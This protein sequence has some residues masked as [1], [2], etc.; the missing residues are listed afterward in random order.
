L[1]LDG[2]LGSHFETARANPGTDRDDQILWFAAELLT[3]GVDRF[4]RD[5]GNYAAPS[6]VN[7]S[8][9]PILWIGNQYRK[10]IGGPDGEPDTGPV[11]DQRVSF[12]LRPGRFHHQNTVGVNLFSARYDT[13]SR[14]PGAK[15]SAEPVFE[16]GQ[17][18]ERFRSK[19]VVVAVP[20]QSSL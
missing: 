9:R 4:T 2:H 12:A 1:E 14:P 20:E 18:L 16:P 15:P 19:N 3:H 8:H 17:R 13:V 11:R 10:T 5:L 7:R 6:G